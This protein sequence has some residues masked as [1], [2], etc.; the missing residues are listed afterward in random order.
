MLSYDFDIFI[1]KAWVCETINSTRKRIHFN[2]NVPNTS[3]WNWFRIVVLATYFL[4]KRV[5]F[6]LKLHFTLGVFKRSFFFFE[7]FCI[8]LNL[9]HKRRKFERIVA[10]TIPLFSPISELH[11]S[12]TASFYNYAR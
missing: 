7:K 8:V 9:N 4:K 5:D 10:L 12:K 2:S 3:T 6:Y 11:A 1:D